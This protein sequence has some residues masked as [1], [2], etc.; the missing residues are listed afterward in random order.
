MKS[1]WYRW[2]AVAAAVVVLV[3]ALRTCSSD[4]NLADRD[5]GE[6]IEAELT[7]QT[8]TLEQPDENGN[9][10]WRL[11]AESV[12]YSPDKQRAELTGL[13]GEF[14]QADE[15]I[16]TVKA[17]QG[18]VQQNGETLFLSGNL[19]ATSTE[20]ELTM[21]GEKLKWQPKQDLLVLGNFEGD[22]LTEETGDDA[23]KAPVTGFNPQ[24][25]A[26][27][28]M[29]QVS[30]KENRVEL[31]GDVVA[32][33]K[34]SPWMAFTSDHLIWLTEQKVIEADQPLQV[35]QYQSKN[36]QTVSD[37]ITG[38]TGQVQLAENIVTLTEAVQLDLLSQPLKVSSEIA[39]WDVD[40]E[41][42][43]LDQPVNINQPVRKITASAN[44]ASLDL[45]QKIIYL[46]GNVRANG[47]KNDTRLTAD[48][49]TWQTTSQQIEAE[50][51]VRYQ[52]AAN[53]EVSMSGPKATGNLE[54][55]TVVITGGESGEVVTEIVP[56]EF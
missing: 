23:D 48:R 41:T 2:T 16:Y 33:S 30:N 4:R 19:V 8:V 9:L 45:A 12:T 37:R 3:V 15:I 34:A 54:Q 28:Q 26:V 32:K 35:E 6:Q 7:L 17:D 56:G 24:V 53:P 46:V 47:E 42:V 10:L 55:G 1:R 44:Q 18:E 14:F 51:N 25:E 27:A 11:K 31:T 43:Q 50:G 52:Q 5:P 39:V 38:Q 22:P 21:K 20:N 40:A 49:V 29:M 36:F 13:D